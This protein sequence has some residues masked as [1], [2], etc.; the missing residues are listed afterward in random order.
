MSQS[1]QRPL[2]VVQSQA[3]L[4]PEGNRTF[5]RMQIT[6]SFFPINPS[7]VVGLRYFLYHEE[8]LRIQLGTRR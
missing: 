8:S 1:S 5:A 2:D 4:T 7:Y 3:K 6:N